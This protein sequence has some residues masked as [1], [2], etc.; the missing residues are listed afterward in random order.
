M[1]QLKLWEALH[2][3][4]VSGALAAGVSAVAPWGARLFTLLRPT[5]QLPPPW[6]AQ[7]LVEV[8]VLLQRLST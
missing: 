7:H 3:C 6:I 5:L 2:L 8:V 1:V 4:I